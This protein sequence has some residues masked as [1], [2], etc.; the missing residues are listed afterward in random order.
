[1]RRDTV[2][3]RIRH[4]FPNLPMSD[5]NFE[6]SLLTIAIGGTLAL[7]IVILSLRALRAVLLKLLG[8]DRKIEKVISQKKSSEVRLGHISEQLAPVLEEFP[9]EVGKPG[10]S[11][12]FLGQPVDYVYF[13]PE[14]GVSFI[15]IKSGASRLNAVQRALRDQIENGRVEWHEMRI[16]APPVKRKRRTV[17]A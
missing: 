3:E 13:D 6:P 7:L 5:L 15:E 12:V 10:T 2:I 17:K 9:V 14:E 1:M 4:S 16:G 11:L 8:V